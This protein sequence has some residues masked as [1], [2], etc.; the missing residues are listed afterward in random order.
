MDWSGVTCVHHSPQGHDE[1][2]KQ[3]NSSG[4]KERGTGQKGMIEWVGLWDKSDVTRRE[5]GGTEEM[6]Y[7]FSFWGTD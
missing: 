2:V 3:E 6:F 5:G 1:D 7:G 4:T